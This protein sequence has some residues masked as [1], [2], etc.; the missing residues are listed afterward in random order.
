MKWKAAHHQIP[1]KTNTMMPKN[2]FNNA[3]NKNMT[4]Y[5]TKNEN[6]PMNSC[7]LDENI[8][9]GDKPI[10]IHSTNAMKPNIILRTALRREN[11][12]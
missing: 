12:F 8:I 5:L 7:I 2:M 4:G 11:V 6:T 10:K 1:M 9:V 3:T